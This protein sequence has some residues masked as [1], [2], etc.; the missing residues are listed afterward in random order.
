MRYSVLWSAWTDMESM[1]LSWEVK[2]LVPIEWTLIDHLGISMK[3]LHEPY[4]AKWTIQV[5][6][7]GASSLRQYYRT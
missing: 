3:V 7:E 1:E 4:R 5:S 6:V 2:G